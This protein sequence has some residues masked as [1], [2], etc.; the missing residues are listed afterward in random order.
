M[1]EPG[2]FLCSMGETEEVDIAV[3][4]DVDRFIVDEF[5][6][7]TLLGDISIWLKHGRIGCDALKARVHANIGEIVAGTK[8]GRSVPGERILAIVQGMAICDLALA[9][10]ALRQ[11][12]ELGLGE[13]L[14]LFS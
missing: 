1:L 14:S 2:S 7:A 13:E 6:Y 4:D 9:H 10:E 3:L 5:E 8:P 11:A 12:A